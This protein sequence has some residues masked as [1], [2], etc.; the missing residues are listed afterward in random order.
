[1]EVESGS[2]GRRLVVVSSR[3]GGGKASTRYWT[4]SIKTG[5]SLPYVNVIIVTIVIIIIIIL[6]Q[7]KRHMPKIKTISMLSTFPF[8]HC[9]WH[10]S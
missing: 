5:A 6:S 3:G 10:L 2:R 1:M 4:I 8:K 9:I 7:V